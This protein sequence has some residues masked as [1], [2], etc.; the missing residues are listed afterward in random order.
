AGHLRKKLEKVF[1]EK[2]GEFVAE[3]DTVRRKVINDLA[4]AAQRKAVLG[5]LVNDES[6]EYFG[7]NG[8]AAWRDRAEKIILEHKS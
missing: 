4:D 3:L 1:T 5:E 7:E 6:F 8:P 2:H